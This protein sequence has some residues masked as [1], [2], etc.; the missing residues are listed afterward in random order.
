MDTDW[1]FIDPA[2]TEVITLE[3]ILRG[4]S[5]VL[6]VTHDA[7]DGAWQFL[8]GDHVFEKDGAVV[9]GCH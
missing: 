3:R 7:E 5:S 2:E 1:P 8:D 9:S 4:E 6:L